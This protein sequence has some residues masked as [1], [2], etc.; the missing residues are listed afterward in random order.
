VAEELVEPLIQLEAAAR[1]AASRG[2]TARARE[3]LYER[4]R[5]A[6]EESLPHNSLVLARLISNALSHSVEAASASAPLGMPNSEVAQAEW[7]SDA[8]HLP[9]SRKVLMLCDARWRA[10]TLFT[11]TPEE[12]VY[13]GGFDNIP[14][15]LN[16]ALAYQIHA[17]EAL[18]YWPPQSTREEEE[19]RLHAVHGALRAALELDARGVLKCSSS[20]TL[21]TRVGAPATSHHGISACHVCCLCLAGIFAE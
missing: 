18:W 1:A 4:L 5:A 19:A 17:Y 15:Q 2:R 21:G 10:G 3:L 12:H 14:E 16:G 11:L 7:R 13:F 8:R 20:A 6:A 9:L